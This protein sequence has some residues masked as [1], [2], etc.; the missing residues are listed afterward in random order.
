MKK[1]LPKKRTQKRNLG[2]DKLG[3]FIKGFNNSPQK[4]HR[5]RLKCVIC[6]NLTKPLVLS[7][8]KFGRGKTCSKKC[9]NILQGIRQRNNQ[10]WGDF[11]K[12]KHHSPNTEFKKGNIVWNKDSK[13]RIGKNKVITIDGER[14]YESHLVWFKHFGHRIPKGYVLHHIDFNADNNNIKN[15]VLMT[16]SEHIKLHHNLWRKKWKKN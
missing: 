10:N 7:R 8:I 12:G 15:L 11:N 16:R 9:K 5:I 3:R 13:V 14:F 2:R 1:E 4:S 6:G